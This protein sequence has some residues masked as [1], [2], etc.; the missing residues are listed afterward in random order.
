M[1][2]LSLA[3][4]PIIAHFNKKFKMP[5]KSRLV[6]GADVLRKKTVQQKDTTGKCEYQRDVGEHVL[7]L[8]LS[9]QFFVPGHNP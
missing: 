9:V 3:T 6:G 4:T 8:S 1:S 5:G 7:G 2:P